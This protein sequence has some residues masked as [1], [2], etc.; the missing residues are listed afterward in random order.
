MQFPNAL[1]GVKKIYKAEIIA[2]IGA[3]IGFVAAILGVVGL[4]SGSVGG[5]AGAGVLIIAMSVLFIISFLMNIG[6]LNK[7]KPDEVNFKNALYMVIAGIVL[8]VVVG[9]TKEGTLL[10]TLGN[11][12]SNVCNLLVNYL[13]ATALMNLANRL[14]D[15]AVAQKAKSVRSLLTAVWVIAL[16]LHILGDAFTSK[17]GMIAGV[18]ALIAS[19]IEIIAYIVYLGLLNKSRGM[20]EA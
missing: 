3:V 12:L 9:A 16:V 18:L 14:G 10:H 7:A 6:G 19:V 17:A 20:L 15:A 11:S 4:A 1:E 2:L 5:L 13:V 8:S